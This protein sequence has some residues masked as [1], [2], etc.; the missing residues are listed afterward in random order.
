MMLGDPVAVESRGFGEPG[1]ID[2]LA[3]SL[4]P[5]AAAGSDRRLIEDTETEDRLTRYHN[6]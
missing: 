3:Q 6:V 1:K 4:A 2:D 5:A